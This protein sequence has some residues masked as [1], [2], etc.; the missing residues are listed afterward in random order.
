MAGLRAGPLFSELVGN[1]DEAV[2]GM[3]ASGQG[4][5]AYEYSTTDIVVG[6]LLNALEM[7]INVPPP[8]GATFILELHKSSDVTGSGEYVRVRIDKS[9]YRFKQDALILPNFIP[10]LFPPVLLQER[11]KISTNGTA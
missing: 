11:N 6:T 7:P 10:S 5:R 2:Q 8:Y 9:I 1:M 3:G 4:K